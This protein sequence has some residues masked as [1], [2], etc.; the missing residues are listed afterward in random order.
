M[1]LSI[2]GEAEEGLMEATYKLC[3]KWLNAFLTHWRNI[4]ADAVQVIPATD[5]QAKSFLHVGCATLNKT[6]LKGFNTD[7]WR[8][9]RFDIDKSV[10]P[11]IVGTLTDMSLV[12]SSSVDAV[13]S[14]HNIEHVFAHEVPV[15]LKEFHRV[16]KPDGIAVITCPDLQSVCEAV[17]KHGL[18]TPLY[19][20]PM[21]PISAI[22]ILYGHRRSIAQGKVY[23]AHKCGFTYPTMQESVFGAGF[24]RCIGA[25]RPGAFDLWLI[26]FKQDLSEE[27]MCK[28]A[29]TYLP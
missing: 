3:L 1:E 6:G 21:G 16:L 8:E 26:A 29:S 20:S 28:A 13:Y 14:S 9:I 23:M 17:A 5:S 19:I 15:A 11:D 7:E 27:A 2:A 10:N 4:R 24:K 22:D 18:L 12:Q 25:S